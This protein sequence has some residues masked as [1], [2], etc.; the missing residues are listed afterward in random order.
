MKM[1]FAIVLGSVIIAAAIVWHRV[2][3][4]PVAG[5][6]VAQ[7][8][9]LTKRTD[10]LQAILDEIITDLTGM[11]TV[12][13]QWDSIWG[14]PERKILTAQENADQMSKAW[15]HMQTINKAKQASPQVAE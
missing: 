10:N 4:P 8:E 5:D 13:K 14:L 3:A 9:N 7:I 11:I 6:A 15:T 1:P 2:S 12:S